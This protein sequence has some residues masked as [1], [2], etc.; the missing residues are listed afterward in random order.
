MPRSVA[1][2]IFRHFN[3]IDYSGI[4]TSEKHLAYILSTE[5]M[6]KVILSLIKVVIKVEVL[7]LPK[8]FIEL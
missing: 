8:I 1:F 5:I 2:F 7:S 4:N 6:C 3:Q